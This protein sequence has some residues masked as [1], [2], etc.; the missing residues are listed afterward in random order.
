MLASI[1]HSIGANRRHTFQLRSAASSELK[2]KVV[3]A[4]NNAT[5]IFYSHKHNNLQSRITIKSCQRLPAQTSRESPGGPRIPHSQLRAPSTV[6]EHHCSNPLPQKEES[7]CTL[8]TVPITRHRT[9][10]RYLPQEETISQLTSSSM[11]TDIPVSMMIIFPPHL[12]T[13]F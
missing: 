5:R 6:A 4:I 13:I 1:T 9:R 12:D 11:Q 8:S 10:A 2:S 3:Y 7:N